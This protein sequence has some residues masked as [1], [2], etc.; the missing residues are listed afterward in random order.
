MFHCYSGSWEHAKRILN[1]GWYISFTGTITFKNARRV[2]ETVRN[3]PADR[4]MVETD[5]PY[6]T[7]VPH[8]GKRNDSS[9]VSFIC[10][11]VAELRGI[12][13]RGSRVDAAEW[14]PLFRFRITAI[15]AQ[16]HKTTRP[17]IRICRRNQSFSQWLVLFSQK[18]PQPAALSFCGLRLR[19]SRKTEVES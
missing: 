18:L 7:P 12:T 10:D 14:Q 8:R 2:L 1:L 3:M 13:R 11:K 19:V 17:L 9:Y 4:I 16:D 6:M 5:A 15:R